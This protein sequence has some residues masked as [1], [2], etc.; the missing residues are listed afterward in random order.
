MDA[1]A[2][3]HLCEL[4]YARMDRNGSDSDWASSLGPILTQDEFQDFREQRNL[5]KYQLHGTFFKNDMVGF[6][7][8]DQ[9]TVNVVV[10]GTSSLINWF[11]N[12]VR[13]PTWNIPYGEYGYAHRG[14][15]A[16]ADSIYEDIGRLVLELAAEGRDVNL[17]GH[18]M[19]G[20]VVGSLSSL[21]AD[22]YLGGLQVKHCYSFGSPKWASW[23]LAKRLSENATK[24]VRFCITDDLVP[25]LP[26][27]GFKHFGRCIYFARNGVAQLNPE[28]RFRAIDR[29]QSWCRDFRFWKRHRM[30][31][32]IDHIEG[33]PERIH[34][35]LNQ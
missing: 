12:L 31:Q 23:R 9:Q 21:F 2:A 8:A 26:V 11:T 13:R 18:S 4:S 25:V 35:L 27:V 34:T 24:Y 5:P 10:R 22:K 7:V 28:R 30:M 3:A 17:M 20:S 16:S 32:Y 14:Y 15:S 1:L 29:I 33:Q 19:G 6:W